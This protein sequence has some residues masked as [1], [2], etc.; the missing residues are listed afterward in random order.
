MVRYLAFSSAAAFVAALGFAAPASALTMK[1][2]GAKYQ[3]AKEAN[4]LKGMKWNDFRK[5][6]CAD[7]DASAT[8]AAAAVKDDD[9][10]P[11]T[12]AATAAE[13]PTPGKTTAATPKSSGPVK[14]PTE[15][16]AK[17]ANETPGKARMHTCVD[18]YR[19]NKENG[20]NG[21][22]K[23]IMKGGGYYS[24]CNAKLKS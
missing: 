8:E 19:A 23:W 18:Q 12:A 4:A 21:D 20:G 9:E 7:E 5:A 22:L 3:A 1:E 2:C 11:A 13:K 6:E 16:S 24:Q 17:Y 14:F 10:K 15:V